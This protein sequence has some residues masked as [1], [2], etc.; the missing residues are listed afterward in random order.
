MLGMLPPAAEVKNY[1][2]VSTRR[3]LALVAGG[4]LLVVGAVF[5]LAALWLLLAES[6]GAVAA[7]LVLASAL[8]GAGLVVIALA[9]R[10]VKMPLP[11]NPLRKEAARGTIFTPTG[12]QPPLLEALLFGF[13]VALQIRNRRR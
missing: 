4:A 5:V 11:S 7:N 1:V 2:H 9:P 3:G 12:Q 6:F 10:A 13:S 8:V